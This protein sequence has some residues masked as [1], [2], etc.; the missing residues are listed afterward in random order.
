MASVIG[1]WR[2]ITGR[3]IT[4]PADTLTFIVEAYA[5][6][7]PASENG[8][9]GVLFTLSDTLGNQFPVPVNSPGVWFPYFSEYTSS[10]WISGVSGGMSP[11]PNGYGFSIP[12]AALPFGTIRCTAKVVANNGAEYTL[13]YN[14]TVF[15]DS[16]GGDRRPSNKVLYVAPIGG[17]GN[18]SNPGTIGSPLASMQKAVTLAVK[19]RATAN[20]VFADA[21]AG[22]AEI[23]LLDG[24]HIWANNPA[25]DYS[26]WSEYWHTGDDWWLTIKS[27]TGNAII[28]RI[29]ESVNKSETQ[30]PES[31]LG[32]FGW[33]ANATAPYQGNRNIRLANVKIQGAGAL[34]TTTTGVRFWLDGGESYSIAPRVT[35]HTVMYAARIADNGNLPSVDSNLGFMVSSGHYRHHVTGGWYDWNQLIDCQIRYTVGITTIWAD[36]K[37]GDMVNCVFDDMHSYTNPGGAAITDGYVWV[38]DG[39]KLSVSIP[40]PGLMRVDSTGSLATLANDFRSVTTNGFAAQFNHI[41]S[42]NTTLSDNTLRVGF[43]NFPAASNN[44]IFPLVSAGVNGNGTEYVVCQ[45]PSA[46]AQVGAG[47]SPGSTSE[48]F[49]AT[50][51]TNQQ[52]NDAIHPDILQFIGSNS[53]FLVSNIAVRNYIDGQAWFISAAGGAVTNGWFVNIS[54]GG[55]GGPASQVSNFSGT[56]LIDCGFVN[57]NFTGDLQ[58]GGAGTKTNTCFVNN[59]FRL[60]AQTPAHGTSATSCY[61]TNNHW[62]IQPPTFGADAARGLNSSTGTWYNAATNV[63]PFYLTPLVGNLGTGS[64]FNSAPTAL[65]WPGTAAQTKG[66][67]RNVGEY[68]Y[69]NMSGG[70]GPVTANATPINVS[71]GILAATASSPRIA[72]AAPIAISLSQQTASVG[73]RVNQVNTT[74]T[75]SLFTPAEL[76]ASPGVEDYRSRTFQ[77]VVEGRAGYVYSHEEDI[78]IP[79]SYKPYPFTIEPSEISWFVFGAGK[80]TTLRITKLNHLTA[81]KENITTVDI[82][83]RTPDISWYLDNG[84]LVLTM[85]M[86]TRVHI[87]VN[88]FPYYG[89]LFLHSTPVKEAIPAGATNFSLSPTSSLAPGSVTYFPP[90]VY[91]IG[92]RFPIGSNSTV[93]IDGG[94]VLRGTLDVTST[95]GIKIIGRGTILTDFINFTDDVEPLNNFYLKIRYS[96]IYW[97]ATVYPI[98]TTNSITGITLAASPYY[99]TTFGGFSNYQFIT[100]LNCWHYEGNNMYPAPGPYQAPVSYVEHCLLSAADDGIN[101]DVQAAL[102]VNKCFIQ[103]LA[104]AVFNVGYWPIPVWPFALVTQDCDAHHLGI[105]DNDI[106]ATPGFISSFPPK[107]GNSVIRCFTDGADGEELYGRFFYGFRGIRVWGPI[108]SRFLS[109]GNYSYPYDIANQRNL[110][111]QIATWGFQDITLEHVPGQPSFIDGLDY[112]NTPHDID[113]LNVQIAG[114]TLSKANRS[115]YMNINQHPYKITV[116]GVPL[117]TYVVAPSAVYMNLSIVPAS[118]IVGTIANGAVQNLSLSARSASVTLAPNISV[119]SS[120]IALTANQASASVPT[121]PVVSALSLTLN[122]HSASVSVVRLALG[123]VQSLSLL[124]QNQPQNTI[125]RGSLQTIALSII[126]VSVRTGSS[127]QVAVQSMSLTALTQSQPTLASNT[128]SNLLLS[129]NQAVA[130][131][132]VRVPVT[133]ITMALLPIDAYA[134]NPGTVIAPVVTMQML[135][136]TQLVRIPVIVLAQTQNVA[137][138]Q[139]SASATTGS[140]TVVARQNL[141]F[142]IIPGETATTATVVNLPISIVSTAPDASVRTGTKADAPTLVASLTTMQAQATTSAEI[143]INPIYMQLSSRVASA[144][145]PSSSGVLP[146]DVLL[147]ILD[148]MADTSVNALATPEYMFLGAGDS[149]GYGI[150]QPPSVPDM[151]PASVRESLEPEILP[152][153]TPSEEWRIVQTS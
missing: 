122:Q 97:D 14:I 152:V 26:L 8:V 79:S 84:D 36:V 94:A 67:W 20:S 29:T 149:E 39:S 48:M 41:I 119:L 78:N 143:A 52:W 131:G 77:V 83:P 127:T 4:N 35:D 25:G 69:Q 11:V 62:I 85:P 38:V 147:T 33:R 145:I 23:I 88:N 43:R 15:N 75:L 76:Y 96:Q 137:L 58:F 153:L 45:N 2:N 140:R 59:V 151:P 89:R 21:D 47:G 57:C 93:Y 34:R 66:V 70:S 9:A 53:N 49:T 105:I 101:L 98:N 128:V 99:S 114:T 91:D 72:T 65:L 113:F 81:V 19:N 68:S 54:D 50:A 61:W 109:L 118:A 90:G 51:R 73:I 95:T 117:S 64:S 135:I 71:L 16:D 31:G 112:L 46:V 5:N 30:Y 111:G 115:T 126:S 63:A 32:C 123:S 106:P 10:K 6:A 3:R 13:P 139:L 130:V 107:G 120:G 142:T 100:N 18:D 133:P 134:V 74:Q 141:L 40:S 87:M 146:I 82:V 55:R 124:A 92:L 116:D 125:A 102:L 56:S 60:T 27:L 7:N 24:T 138:S 86:D 12:V 42:A 110:K 44:G 104:N 132:T 150:I 121:V 80:N 37:G 17:G 144:Q 108:Y 22:G 136:F 1:K 28:T 129:Q 148:A 103:T